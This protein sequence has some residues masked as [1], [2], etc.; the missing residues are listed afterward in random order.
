MVSK[1]FICWKV[2]FLVDSTIQHL[3]NQG[4]IINI[5][6]LPS[7]SCIS[8][9]SVNNFWVCYVKDC[10]IINSIHDDSFSAVNSPEWSGRLYFG[11]YLPIRVWNLSDNRQNLL[12]VLKTWFSDNKLFCVVWAIYLFFTNSGM[13]L[14]YCRLLITRTF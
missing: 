14:Y 8:P 5:E 11:P 13:P 7:F 4:L 3:N 12:F 9:A 6:I 1:S 10:I 2:I